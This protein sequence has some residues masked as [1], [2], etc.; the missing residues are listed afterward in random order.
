MNRKFIYKVTG[1]LISYIGLAELI[2]GIIKVD[3]GL[4]L[5]GAFFAFTGS[6]LH[7]LGEE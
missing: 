2:G 4:F 5:Y 6:C 1:K 7:E 3:I